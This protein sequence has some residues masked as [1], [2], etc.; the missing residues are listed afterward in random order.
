MANGQPHWDSQVSRVWTSSQFANVS[1]E[2]IEEL[3]ISAVPKS[4][5][6][7]TKYGPTIFKG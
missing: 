7:A 4:M 3:N 6:Y 2:E 1:D 5:Q